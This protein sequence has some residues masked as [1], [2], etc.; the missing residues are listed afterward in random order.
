MKV[1]E[2]T[3]RLEQSGVQDSHQFGFEFSAKAAS[4]LSGDIYTNRYRAILRELSTNA[5]DSHIAAGHTKPFDVKFP[6][7]FDRTFHVRDYG[8]GL[9]PDEVKDIYAIYFKSNKTHTNDATGCLGLGSKSPFA[10]TDNFFVESYKNS[11]RWVYSLYKNEEG[12]P[13]FSLLYEEKTNE[14]D[15]VKVGFDVTAG[16]SYRFKGEVNNTF[17]YFNRVKPNL[18]GCAHPIEKPETVMSGNGWK[19][20][21]SP[22]DCLNNR[23]QA[24]AVMASVP[25]PIEFQS[26]H[27]KVNM[28]MRIPIEIEFD[29]G[30]LNFTASRE[31]LTYDKRT[32]K[33]LEKRLL[34]VY[35]EIGD[36]AE[37]KLQGCKNLWEKR[38]KIG[39]I[40]NHYPRSLSELVLNQYS[41]RGFRGINH[42][43]HIEIDMKGVTTWHFDRYSSRKEKR[44]SIPIDSNI[45]FYYKDIPRGSYSRCHYIFENK[46][47]V[48]P[49]RVILFEF[50]GDEADAKKRLSK[51]L[52]MDD[53]FEEYVKPTS[54]LPKRPAASRAS[55]GKSTK[56]C[57]FDR[58]AWRPTGAWDNT[59]ID[60][61]QGGVYVELNRF[62]GKINGGFHKYHY[63]KKILEHL[64][65]LTSKPVVVYGIKTA[66]LDSVVKKGKWTSLDEY[67]EKVVSKQCKNMNPEDHVEARA[68]LDEYNHGWCR[69]QGFGGHKHSWDRMIELEKKTNS[70]T[71]KELVSR[72]HQLKAVA[73]FW[74]KAASIKSLYKYMKWTYK[75]KSKIDTYELVNMAEQMV[76]K[77]PLMKQITLNS[78]EDVEHLATYINAIE[79]SGK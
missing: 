6:N 62:Q 27:E 65:N 21:K 2:R 75:F 19:I 54:S 70:K 64:D 79:R 10:Y 7:S 5:V 45:Q 77:Y 22:Y 35:K 69:R 36:I 1:A 41:V 18:I 8:T 63:L 28:M 16:D 55:R 13:Q 9:Y 57:I 31:S 68:C 76:T 61:S 48:S 60:P 26:N 30:T 78:S 4:I 25:Y 50:H 53:D 29:N 58:G 51:H 33:N 11:H 20:L 47:V 32:I 74:H 24:V 37:K 14:P 46:G 49:R 44:H 56:V 59:N 38:L 12:I 23:E 72:Y 39:D 66:V 40:C 67:I 15:G 34:E 71:I 3:R 17:R 43:K 52:G 42:A 73:S